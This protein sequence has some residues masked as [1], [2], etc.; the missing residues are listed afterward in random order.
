MSVLSNSTFIVTR[1]RLGL[2]AFNLNGSDA[3]G[4][5]EVVEWGPGE[6]VIEANWETSPV[7]DG[8]VLS[9]APAGLQNAVLVVRCWGTPA[10]IKASM[11]TVTAAFSQYEYTLTVNIGG[12]TEM[13]VWKC[14]PANISVG[15]SGVWNKEALNGGWQDLEMNIPVQPDLY[16]R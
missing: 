12:S 7:T 10:Q 2:S 3:D 1:T 16:R 6:R 9:T 5:T 4:G 15:D 13:G 11:A 14:H 8:A